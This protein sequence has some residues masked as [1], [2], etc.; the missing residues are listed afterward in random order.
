MGVKI[1][2]LTKK[3]MK[4]IEEHHQKA[5]MLKVQQT[6]PIKL[7]DTP[8]RGG[9][10]FRLREVFGFRP[11]TIVITKVMGRNN[12]I[13]VSAVVPDAVLLREEKDAKRKK[14]QTVDKGPS[15]TD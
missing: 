12:V 2:A 15:K 9:L 14:E 4:Q 11:E 5:P 3:Q 10:E 1:E 13:I 6:K 8:G 7:K